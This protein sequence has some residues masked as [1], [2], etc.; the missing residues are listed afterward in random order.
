MGYKHN[1][2][3]HKKFAKRVVT[4]ETRNSLSLAAK[5]RVPTSEAKNKIFMSRLGKR[6]PLQVREKISDTITKRQGIAI[7]VRDTKPYGVRQFNSFTLAANAL[8]VSRTAVGKAM[9]A[10]KLLKAL[11]RSL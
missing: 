8:Q 11:L 10:H 1:E 6:L 4:D 5:S 2:Q 3:A 7:E 9:D